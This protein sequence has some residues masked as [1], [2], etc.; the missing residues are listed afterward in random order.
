VSE[1][2][3]LKPDFSALA[4]LTPGRVVVTAAG[5]DCDF[6]SRFFATDAGLKEDPVTGSSHCTLV[7]YW[8]ARLGKKGLHARQ[9]SARG[10]ELWCTLDG[11]RV[12]I[13]GHAV[14]YLRGEISLVVKSR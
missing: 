6:V 1:V 9:V 2:V 12:K 8:S 13:A 4:Q 10:G 7:P 11:D 14:L 5:T 3:A